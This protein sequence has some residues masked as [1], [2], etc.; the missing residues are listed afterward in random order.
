[1]LEVIFT[2]FNAIAGG[3][4]LPAEDTKPK[5]AAGGVFDLGDCAVS[6]NTGAA[7]RAIVAAVRIDLII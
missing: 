4:S 2:V 7:V 1:M 5:V 3:T 6:A